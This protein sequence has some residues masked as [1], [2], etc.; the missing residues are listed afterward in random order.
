MGSWS[1]DL[2]RGEG[3]WDEGQC[4]I[5]GIVPGQVTAAWRSLLRFIHPDDR[6]SAKRCWRRLKDC[7]EAGEIELRIVRPSGHVRRCIVVCAAK[8]DRAHRLSRVSGVTID[9]TERRN[10]EDHQALL[11]REVDHRAKNALAIVQAI[12]RLTR[13]PDVSSYV[14]AIEGRIGALSRV[15]SL[16]SK[17][18]WEGAELASIVAEEIQPYRDQQRDRILASGPAILLSPSM[19]Q[20]LGLAFHELATNAAKYGALSIAGGRATLAWGLD[21]SALVIE[22]SESEG[23]PVR[24]PR[25]FGYGIKT[26][27][28]AVERQLRGKVDLDWQTAGLRCRLTIPW[29]E[30]P[31]GLASASR[32]PDGEVAAGRSAAGLQINGARLLLVEDEPLVAM[33][34]RQA[35]SELDFEVSD[36]VGNV[37]QALSE[38]SN[39]EIHAAV[40]D[41]NLGDR[42]AY[43]VADALLARGIPFVFVTGYSR[44]GIEERYASIPVLSKPIDRELLKSYFT[45]LP[46]DLP[47]RPASEPG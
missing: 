11:S 39:R 47:G 24:E 7:G 14:E 18:R 43:P 23:P 10:A 45:R 40:L 13:A 31:R 41:I 34:M 21:G 46:L 9:V 38:I 42:T 28:A 44:Q 33:M 3:T 4:R 29:E 5:F 30:R 2:E 16:L 20:T 15:H 37:E 6:P 17:A 1:F 26:L 35:L 8:L 25:T 19:G 12:V 22:W 36:A 27:R 32:K